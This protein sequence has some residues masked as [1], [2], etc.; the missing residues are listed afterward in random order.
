MTVF[1]VN[2]SIAAIASPPG[3]AIRGVIRL[4]GPEIHSGIQQCF[5]CREFESELPDPVVLTG[6]IQVG[7]PIRR[8]LAELYYWPGTASYTRQRSAEFH[9]VGSL[10]VL[11]EVMKTLAAVGVRQ[12]QPGEFTMRAFLAGRIDLT[13]AE[14]VLGVIDSE[15]DQ[16]MEVALKQ[17]AGG[18]SGPVD[19]LQ[20]D[21]LEMLAEIEAGLDF[22]E[23]DI[24]FI[25]R[26]EVQTRIHRCQQSL[27]QINRQLD[28]RRHDRLRPGVV[29]QGRPNVGKS[30]LLNALAE[31]SKAIVSEISGTTRDYLVST[32]D[33]GSLIIDLIDTAGVMSETESDIAPIHVKANAQTESVLANAALKI[34][35][36]DGTVTLDDWSRSRIADSRKTGE[37]LV[38]VQTKSD[39]QSAWSRN[40]AI[41]VS[42]LTGTGLR[43]LRDVIQCRL[44]DRQSGFVGELVSSTANRCR[45]SLDR[46]G[47]ELELAA[48]CCQL[49]QGD[50]VISAS[51]RMVL[52]ELAIVTGK[53]FT[54]DILDRVFSRF[55]IGK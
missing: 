15:S 9:C 35:C 11:N 10:P 54:D 2:D 4:S 3:P 48:E 24:E 5:D 52:D 21:L 47:R 28:L 23:D 27:E 42:S 25:S 8:V 40:D 37:Q 29:L 6:F 51:L 13:R 1:D 33:I 32:V 34:L 38:V 53:V 43:E 19:Q 36:I 44:Q 14:A 22:V 16:E 17:M 7:N 45:E 41:R 50:E 18:V 39:L 26:D 55:C 20:E 49:G 31:N 12:A 46:A 30:C